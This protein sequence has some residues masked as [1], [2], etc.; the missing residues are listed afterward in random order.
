V[1][2]LVHAGGTPSALLPPGPGPWLLTSDRE[3]KVRA[4][5]RKPTAMEFS[6]TS[7]DDV[8]RYVGELH[9]FNVRLDQRAL[10]EAKLDSLSVNFTIIVKGD[11][12]ENAL[13]NLFS[14]KGFAWFVED[15]T[16]VVTTTA[17]AANHQVTY[18]YSLAE[19]PKRVSLPGTIRHS[20]RRAL[21]NDATSRAEGA[22]AKTS[23]DPAITATKTDVRGLEERLRITGGALIFRGTY[24]EHAQ[25]AKLLEEL[26]RERR[27]AGTGPK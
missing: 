26:R 16:L 27:E 23:S 13:K 6:V 3:G 24:V 18:V 17:A 12:L 15:D 10:E 4:E 7:L 22:M 19:L 11:T 25:V 8:C 5:L 21:E 2:G 1:V 14:A 9:G 20:I